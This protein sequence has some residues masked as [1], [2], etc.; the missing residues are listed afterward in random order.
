MISRRILSRNSHLKRSTKDLFSKDQVLSLYKGK[1]SIINFLS[2]IILESKKWK[3]E[4]SSSLRSQR[5]RILHD[6][7]ME[8]YISEIRR[9]KSLESSKQKS[10]AN[11]L[12]SRL[13][14][15]VSY[16]WSRVAAV[17]TPEFL[18]SIDAEWASTYKSL[19][20]AQVQK[21]NVRIS[22]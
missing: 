15:S 6:K 8:E 13:D 21:K 2:E 18:T 14:S 20:T 16:F 9:Q 11:V 7:G 4:Q 1:L 19:L 5:L 22:M 12:F 17:T 10:I 3:L